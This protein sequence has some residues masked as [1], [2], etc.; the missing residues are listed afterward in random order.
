MKEDASWSLYRGDSAA[1]VVTLLRMFW[2]CMFGSVGLPD[3]SLKQTSSNLQFK[4]DINLVCSCGSRALLAVAPWLSQTV[5]V[6]WLLNQN[7]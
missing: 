2:A 1:H 4:T 3:K 6:E 5:I 7:V